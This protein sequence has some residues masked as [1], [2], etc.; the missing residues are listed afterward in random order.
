VTL[1]EAR[2]ELERDLIQRTLRKHNGN[3]TRTAAELQV[4]RPTLYELME[5]LGIRKPDRATA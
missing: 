4:S 3:M 5:K 1:K 2:E